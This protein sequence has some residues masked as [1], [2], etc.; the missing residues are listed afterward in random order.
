MRIEHR[1]NAAEQGRAA[2]HNLLHP[3]GGKPFEPV[4][5]FSSDHYG[6]RI[7]AYGYLPVHHEVA[8]VDGD[9]EARRFVV[10]YRIGNR[11]TGVLSAGMP[12]EVIRPWRRAIAARAAWPGR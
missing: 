2:A 4:P 1:A 3:G 5:R 12:P 7:Q 11:V 8:L 6:M 10:A 9:L